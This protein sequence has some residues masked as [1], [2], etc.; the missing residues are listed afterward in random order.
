MYK[1]RIIS[2]IIILIFV[3]IGLDIYI[4]LNNPLDVFISL[5]IGTLGPA[6]IIIL[7]NELAYEQREKML[8]KKN[9]SVFMNELNSNLNIITNNRDILENEAKTMKNEEYSDEPLVILKD[10][11]LD[12]LKFNFPN[13]DDEAVLKNINDIGYLIHRINSVIIDRQ[14][15]SNINL[16]N[17]NHMENTMS[18]Y[19]KSLLI[20]LMI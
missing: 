7:Y 14:I 6:A 9:F 13:L 12:L 3:L 17:D 11:A 1:S 2:V 8:E 19:Q 5:I 10:Q 16:T 20:I 4:G 15:Y 18:N